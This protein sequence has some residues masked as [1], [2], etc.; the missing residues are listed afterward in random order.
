MQA[1]W[2]FLLNYNLKLPLILSEHGIYTKERRVDIFLS[3]NFRDDNDIDR[4]LTESSYL[5][6][7]WDRYFKILSQLCY[8]I[9]DP[10]VSLF[11][12]AHKIQLEEGAPAEKAIIIPNGINIERFK[13]MRRP[14]EEKLPIVCFVGRLVPMKD[15]KGFIRAI[16]NVHTQLPKIKFLII[17]STDQDPAYAIE[18][19][20]LV[21]NISMQNVIEFKPHQVMEEVLPKVKILVLSA[22]REGMPFVIIES[23]AAGVPV[24]ATDVGASKEIIEGITEEDKEIG[25]AGIVVK[26]ADPHALEQAIVELLTNE[27]LWHQMSENGIKRVERYYDEKM[28]LEKYSQIYARSMM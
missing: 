22:I 9:A 7:L 18:C 8:S 4:A 25:P 12:A 5:R 21:E 24:V 19:H 20:Q 11:S 10:I 28:M 1:Y 16:P 14:L 26:V 27:K 2:V 13:H 15:V 23:L 17:G 6:N 3:T